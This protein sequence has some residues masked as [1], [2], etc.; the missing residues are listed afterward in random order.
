MKKNSEL[1]HRH[2]NLSLETLT[3]TMRVLEVNPFHPD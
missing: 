1:F 2:F 3:K